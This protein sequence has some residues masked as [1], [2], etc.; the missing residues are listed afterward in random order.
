MQMLMNVV[1]IMAD[2]LSSAIIPLDHSHVSAVWGICLIQMR[3][4]VMV[5]LLQV[6]EVCINLVMAIL[7]DIDECIPEVSSCHEKAFCLNTNG[8]FE[9]SCDEG[10]DGDGFQCTGLLI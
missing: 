8:S 9:C 10:Y 4:I 3:L 1:M 7:S 5:C 2:V 6:G